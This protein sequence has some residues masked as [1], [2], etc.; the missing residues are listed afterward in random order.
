ML[1]VVLLVVLVLMLAAA[2]AVRAVRPVPQGRVGIVERLG[3]YRRTI[4]PGLNVLVP[5]ADRVRTIVDLREQEAEVTA[6]SVITADRL[7][8]SV[9]VRLRY[10]IADPRAATYEIAD[11][12]TSLDLLTATVLRNLVG[13]MTLDQ[14]RASH[15]ELGRHVQTAVGEAAYAWGIDIHHADLTDLS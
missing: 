13:G 10:R 4:Q 8:V 14:A 2:V 5:F 11:V 3:R 1:T 15:H 9:E 12:R 7:P 6:S